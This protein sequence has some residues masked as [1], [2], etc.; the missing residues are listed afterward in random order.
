MHTQAIRRLSI[1]ALALAATVA[2]PGSAWAPPEPAVLFPTELVDI[3]G[4][5]IDVPE[6][7]SDAHLVVVTLKATWCK[8]C[9]HQLERLKTL[10]PALERCGVNVV[11]LSP[12]PRDEL[13][14]IRDRI[15]LPA[16]FVVDDDLAVAR[17][18]GIAMTEDQIFPCM[19]QILPD[20]TI[21]WRQL[22]RNGAYFG[23][24]KLKTYFECRS[25]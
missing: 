21:G 19:L 12:G 5:R 15:G 11:V 8:V 7:A 2:L 24:G 17:A 20:R 9:Q 6:L 14:E 4:Q 3:D 23:D 13:A 18:L 1:A 25:V 10:L 16:S 22:G